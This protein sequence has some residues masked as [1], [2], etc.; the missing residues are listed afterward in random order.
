MLE[1]A[2]RKPA[3]LREQV[4]SLQPAANLHLLSASHA[5]PSNSP[6]R[7]QTAPQTLRAAASRKTEASISPWRL[8][9]E[10][11]QGLLP[12]EQDAAHSP[13]SKVPARDAGAG[14][15]CAEGHHL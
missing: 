5:R 11:P 10:G 13:A 15:A 4:E 8:L 6:E 12:A 1:P 3:K 7:R 14:R 2:R 9:R